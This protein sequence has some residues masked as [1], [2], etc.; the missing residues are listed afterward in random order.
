MQVLDYEVLE[1]KVCAKKGD[2]KDLLNR[3]SGF[4]LLITEE[5]ECDEGIALSYE[6]IV[7]V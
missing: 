6:T 1:M 4:S 2:L 7:V 5:V 3:P